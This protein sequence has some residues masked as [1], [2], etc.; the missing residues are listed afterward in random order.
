MD[1]KITID[2]KITSD[3]DKKIKELNQIPR[4]AYNFFKAE[5][6]IR[7]GR[8]RKNTILKNDTIMARY[9]YAERLDNGYS[10]QAPNGMSKPTEAFVQ[11]TVDRLIKRK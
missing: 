6:P 5:T 7:S 1:F 2:D 10:R 3:L 8:A 4:Q 11:R 9:P